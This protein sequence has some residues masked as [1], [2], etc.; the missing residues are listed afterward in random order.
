MGQA[1]RQGESRFRKSGETG[2]RF[3][4]SRAKVL[5]KGISAANELPQN[6]MKWN[7]PPRWFQRARSVHNLAETSEDL[8]PNSVV[9]LTGSLREFHTKKRLSVVSYNFVRTTNNQ[10][11]L[12]S[13]SVFIPMESG[14]E[15]QRE[16]DLKKSLQ[17]LSTENLSESK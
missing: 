4:N 5:K 11:L 10:H 15:C 2:R 1:I 8:N 3:A 6:L 16:N 7:T 17:S 14:Y 9:G 12:R 13:E